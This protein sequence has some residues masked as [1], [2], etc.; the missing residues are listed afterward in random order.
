MVEQEKAREAAQ[1]L[2][3]SLEYIFVRVEL[4][5]FFKRFGARHRWIRWQTF[6]NGR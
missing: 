3:Q 5:S 4:F 1:K 6:I 2:N